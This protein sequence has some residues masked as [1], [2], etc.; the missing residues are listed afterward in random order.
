[1]TY[2]EQGART[3]EYDNLIACRKSG[4]I[5]DR[6]WTEHLSDPDFAAYV[7]QFAPELV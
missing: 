2:P 7:K 1:M 4:Q 6:Q 5:N 3:S